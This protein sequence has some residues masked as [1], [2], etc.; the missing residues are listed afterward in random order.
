MT[1]WAQ[2][3]I[4][5]EWDYEAIAALLDRAI[6]PVDPA[7]P[8]ARKRLRILGAATDLFAKQGYRKTNIDDIARAAGI[9]KGTV[10]LYFKNKG[11]IAYSAIALEKRKNLEQVRSAFDRSVPPREQL[12][13][14][15][16]TALLMVAD[17]PVLSALLRDPRELAAAMHDM[18]PGVMEQ[19]NAMGL[20]LYGELLQKASDEPLSAE[21]LRD[22]VQLL[23]VIGALARSVTDPQVRGHLSPRRY[24]GLLAHVLVTGLLHRENGDPT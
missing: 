7:D 23:Q 6:G 4:A 15:I 11:A 9:A 13:R 20:E 19:T 22:R 14:F 12:R 3:V 8:K 24:A 2:L 18:P 5:M 17:M 10:Y 16:E 1:K 21:A